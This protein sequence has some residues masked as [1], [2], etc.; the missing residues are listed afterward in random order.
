MP[1]NPH[2]SLLPI[3][4]NKSWLDA[5][6]SILRKNLLY[7][8]GKQTFRHNYVYFPI[9]LVCW[10]WLHKDNIYSAT[11]VVSHFKSV[12]YY[13]VTLFLLIFMLMFILLLLSV[14]DFEGK[15]FHFFRKTYLYLKNL[16]CGSS[17]QLRQLIPLEN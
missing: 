11:S 14:L 12:Y 6:C 1:T 3:K 5:C 16:D 9:L 8:L 15:S 17:F 2:Y 4:L 10:L 7:F 13:H